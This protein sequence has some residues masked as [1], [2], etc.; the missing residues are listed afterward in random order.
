MRLNSFEAESVSFTEFKIEKQ[1]RAMSANAYYYGQEQ[2]TLQIFGISYN[3]EKN[4][5]E[6]GPIRSYQLDYNALLLR[7]WQAY[8]ESS[9]AHTIISK[10]TK[11]IIGSGLKLQ[12]N[13]HMK[14]LEAEGIDFDSEDFNDLV[15]AYFE[16]FCK[17]K[18]S[19]CHGK[20]NLRKQM[21][22]AFTNREVGGDVLV[23]L[24]VSKTGQ[25]T[26]QLIDGAHI[27]NPIMGN[28]Y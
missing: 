24:R 10:K 4:L 16:N 7:S 27:W 12:S 11:A 26:V 15:E 19:D 17:S 21:A 1:E 3:G 13:P 14:V 8:L 2:G 25:I 9:I 22:I 5:G 20:Y 18:S 28:D 6:M 23:I